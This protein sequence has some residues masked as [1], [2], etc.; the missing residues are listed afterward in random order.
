M[1]IRKLKIR[2]TIELGKKINKQTSPKFTK[3]S[4]LRERLILLPH[5]MTGFSVV[6]KV[7]I[8]S[9]IKFFSEGVF[10]FSLY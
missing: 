10:P 1:K 7:K 3:N 9:E 5:R 6:S 8:A 4:T 2:A